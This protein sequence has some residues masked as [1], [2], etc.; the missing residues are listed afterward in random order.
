MRLSPRFGFGRGWRGAA[1][2]Y[3]ASHEARVGRRVGGSGRAAR[4]HLLAQHGHDLGA[5]QLDLFER[6]L[7][8]Q[9]H[10][11]DDPQLALVVAEALLEGQG[12]LDHLLRAADAQRRAAMKSSSE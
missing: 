8:R 4:V 7:H 6:H 10:R 1:S 2:P 9:A 11:V 12:L 5:E 3:F